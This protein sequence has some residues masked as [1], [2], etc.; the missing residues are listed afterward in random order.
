VVFQK[1][2]RD[3]VRTDLKGQNEADIRSEETA[4]REFEAF[5]TVRAETDDLVRDEETFIACSAWTPT[6]GQHRVDGDGRG[7]WGDGR[8][9]DGR[10]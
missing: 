4:K 2:R 1:V 7:L 10:V 8:D 5:C 6:S 9:A 3:S